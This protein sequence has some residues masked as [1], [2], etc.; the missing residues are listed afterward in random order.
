MINP[1][2]P[3]PFKEGFLLVKEVKALD[4]YTVRIRYDKPYA[5]AVETGGTTMLPKHLLQSFADAGTLRESP[6][7]S[8]PL[9]TGPYRSHAWKPGGE[10]AMLANHGHHD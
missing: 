10:V 9:A 7:N 2:T 5:R 1:K 6:Q 4:P 8:Q 3:A